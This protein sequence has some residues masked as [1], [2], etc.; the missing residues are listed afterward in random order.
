[1]LC[2][3]VGQGKSAITAALVLT[4]NFFCNSVSKAA[5]RSS[6]SKL[7]TAM[8]RSTNSKQCCNHM[9]GVAAEATMRGRA[10]RAIA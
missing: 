4:P 2:S 9:V 10:G 5:V 1:M 3:N 8:S 6:T 7:V